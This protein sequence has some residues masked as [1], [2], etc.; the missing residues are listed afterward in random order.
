MNNNLN[1]LLENLEVVIDKKCLE[2]KNNKKQKR[3]NIIITVLSL[4]F[5]TIPSILLLFNI[6]IIYFIF[7][8]I[9]FILLVSFIKL[10]DILK[11]NL[12]VNCYE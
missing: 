4:N 12:E 8:F 2:I 5:I 3:K 10:P 7:G 9:I 1:K 6:N 11:K